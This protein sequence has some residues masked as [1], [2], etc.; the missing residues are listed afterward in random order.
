MKIPT[1]KFVYSSSIHFVNTPC[2]KINRKSNKFLLNIEISLNGC[3]CVQCFLDNEFKQTPIS[4]NHRSPPTNHSYQFYRQWIVSNIIRS[5]VTFQYQVFDTTIWKILCKVQWMLCIRTIW[6]PFPTRLE[7]WLHRQW[8]RSIKKNFF[9]QFR[10][11]RWLNCN[12]SI[13]WFRQRWLHNDSRHV[14]T[15]KTPALAHPTVS[16]ECESGCFIKSPLY[17]TSFL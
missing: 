15:S 11:K 3:G 6:A 4:K 1:G 12:N 7:F 14:Q 10:T 13:K 17:V 9:K 8:L 5:D 2:Q 16:I